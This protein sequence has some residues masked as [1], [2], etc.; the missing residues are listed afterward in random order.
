MLDETGCDGIMIARGTLGN[1]WIFQQVQELE[2]SGRY[3]PVSTIDR[4]DIIAKHL[5]FFIE[6]LGEAISVREIKKH[7]GWYAKGFAGASEIRRAANSADSIQDIQSLVE[8]IRNV[9]A[10][11]GHIHGTDAE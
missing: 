8:R 3:T 4:A 1:P 5:D 10:N 6:E 7:I 9:P 2:H 11:P